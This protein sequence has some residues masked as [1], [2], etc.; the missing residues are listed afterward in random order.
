M[1]PL[2]REIRTANFS[3]QTALPA[4]AATLLHPNGNTTSPADDEAVQNGHLPGSFPIAHLA[5][6]H[7]PSR[8]A[9]GCHRV[10]VIYLWGAYTSATRN[11][12][13]I[14]PLR[15]GSMTPT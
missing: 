3:R 5:H 10:P 6:R 8:Q 12:V 2:N 11:S 9:L 15:Y 14:C 1:L 4:L 13:L 7:R